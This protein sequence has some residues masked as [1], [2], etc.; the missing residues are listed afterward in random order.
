MWAKSKSGCLQERPGIQVNE[1]SNEFQTV[2]I[3]CLSHLLTDTWCMR[4]VPCLTCHICCSVQSG[5]SHWP[6]LPVYFGGAVVSV[7]CPMGALARHL[8]LLT[9]CSHLFHTLADFLCCN[10]DRQFV[11]LLGFELGS[12][13]RSCNRMKVSACWWV[14]ALT[15]AKFAVGSNQR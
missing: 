13:I 1:F 5:D 11:E 6:A 14:V 7:L 12:W 10:Y 2:C 8:R 15:I 4:M 3:S 9:D